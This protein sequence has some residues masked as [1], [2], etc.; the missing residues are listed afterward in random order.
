MLS[1]CGYINNQTY[2]THPHH[3]QKDPRDHKHLLVELHVGQVTPEQLLVGGDHFVGFGEVALHEG[4]EGG[5]E[6]V[7]EEHRVSLQVVKGVG[8][9]GQENALW[10]F[11][12][13]VVI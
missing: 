10:G 11:M 3:R 4:R 8:N 7:A 1:Y 12:I 2:N 13:I 5:E 9:Q 6:R